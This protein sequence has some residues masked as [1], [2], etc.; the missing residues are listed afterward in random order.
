MIHHSPFVSP[1]SFFSVQSFLLSVFYCPSYVL[2]SHYRSLIGPRIH[3]NVCFKSCTNLRSYISIWTSFCL[4]NH[5]IASVTIRLNLLFGFFRGIVSRFCIGRRLRQLGRWID[6]STSSKA[7]LV[8][9]RI[10]RFGD[11]S[12]P[13]ENKNI[14]NNSWD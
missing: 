9:V 8:L 7:I 6:S 14:K 10:R 2:K 5:T 3:F 11:V 13:S 1:F 12:K 4:V